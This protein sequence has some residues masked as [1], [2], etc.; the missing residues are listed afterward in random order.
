MGTWGVRSRLPSGLEPVRL[1]TVGLPA[2]VRVR[3]RAQSFICD[4][5]SGASL[6]H[7]NNANLYSESIDFEREIVLGWVTILGV[8]V[9]AK[10]HTMEPRS[11]QSRAFLNGM[12]G[13]LP[14]GEA[15]HCP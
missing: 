4:R 12:K 3:A 1:I 13:K 8:E 7:S 14:P 15:E 9:S 5:S 10:L 2:G 6:H 11:A